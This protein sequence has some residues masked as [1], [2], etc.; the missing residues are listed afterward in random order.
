MPDA[1]S[2]IASY[3]TVARDVLPERIAG[4]LLSLIAER[5][6]RPGDKLPPERELAATMR[7]SR[8]SLREALRALAMLNIVEIRQGSGTY[9]SS[10][11]PEVLIE[12]LDFV[13]AIDDSTFSELLEARRILE[14]GLAAAA[15]R[16]ATEEE[17][18]QM[19]DCV[20]RAAAHLDD[21]EVFLTVDLELHQRI[22]A[23]AHNQIIAHIMESLTRLGMASRRRTAALPWVRAKSVQDHQA[24]VEA[25]MGRDGEAA[26]RIMQRHLEAVQSGLHEAAAQAGDR[27]TTSGG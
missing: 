4:Q 1:V 7:V 2:T 17:L 5:K 27:A 12:R 23:A 26:A 19:R 22:A 3:G 20:I 14:P 11:K 8:P 9:V 15:A 21:P 18:A 25:L 6:L 16:H 13:F 10:L 24:I